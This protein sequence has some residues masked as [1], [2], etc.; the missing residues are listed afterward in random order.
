MS[1]R[2]LL[3][4]SSTAYDTVVEIST[5]AITALYETLKDLL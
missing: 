4:E 2:K 3:Q 5:K 1:K